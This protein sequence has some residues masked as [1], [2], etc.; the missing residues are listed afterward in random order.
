MAKMTDATSLTATTEETTNLQRRSFLLNGLRISL[1]VPL[2]TST[3]R[4]ELC[5]DP[6]ELS[7][8]DYSFRK[9]VEYT[10]SSPHKDKSCFG[11]NSFKPP[12]EGDCGTCR[13]VAGKI[14]KNGHCTG[15]EAR[16]TG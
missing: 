7:S 6:E 16:K 15:W 10:E 1:A 2:L 9:Y 14:N 5:E 11:C 13:A 3:A 4:A 12:A 8:V